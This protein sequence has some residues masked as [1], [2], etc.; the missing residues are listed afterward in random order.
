M[1]VTQICQGVVSGGKDGTWETGG[2]G[3]LTTN[4]DTQKLGLWP[5]GFLTLEVEGNWGKAVN[6]NT[7]AL[8][9][10]NSN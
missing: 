7:G 10:A 9:P 6:V 4:L 8:M 5:G 3:T 2:R 1:N